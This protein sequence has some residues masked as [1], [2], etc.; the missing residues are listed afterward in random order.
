MSDTIFAPATV[1]GRSA[2]A[3]VRLS[4]P[5]AFDVARRL[6][7]DLPPPRQAGL[8][9]LRDPASGERL[10]QALVLTFAG[11]ASFTGEDCVELQTHG[12]GAVLAG[13]LAALGQVEGARLAEPGEFTRR[14][15]MNDCLDLAQVE[16]LGDLLAAET[17]AQRRQAIELMD[18]VLSGLVAEWRAA[19][20]GVL[21]LVEA[22]IDFSDEE[23]PAD[24]LDRAGTAV[25]EIER[26]MR[27]E[28]DGANAGERLRDG[29]EVALVGLPNVGKSTLVNRLAGR[30]L[31]LVSDEAG[32]TRDVIEARLELAGLPV[33]VLDM[34]GL[35]PAEG[36]EAAGV[37]RARGRATAA[38][39]R[40]FLVEDAADLARL[41][42]A[43]RAEDLVVRA[44]ADRTEGP[45]V[46]GL[47]GKGIEA[48]LAE[49]AAVLARRAGRMGAISHAR[50]RQATERA[51]A[52][53]AR[54]EPLLRGGA[55]E[56]AAEELRLALR[57]LD[58]LVGRV[59]VEAVLDVIF[60]S[61]CLGK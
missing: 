54:A 19:L 35:R 5:R 52:A 38:D 44:K 6:V 4:G 33:T 2:V 55:T 34:A 39:L 37:A 10:D 46:S 9:W 45:G 61:F 43:V 11:P 16:G 13:V 56:L 32:T 7:T 59:D 8:R 12:G 17:A 27:R 40:V 22:S 1:L 30:E 57:S 26:A 50:Q 31:A 58:F 47:T 36:I 48:L 3:I 15:L 14:A 18:G 29:F 28:L 51:A 60:A 23:L 24:L 25:A 21:A 41:A 53:L 49:I 20:T 42:V